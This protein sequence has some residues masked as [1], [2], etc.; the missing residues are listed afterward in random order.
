MGRIKTKPTKRITRKLMA[1]H[2][3]EFTD[4]FGKN[5]EVVSRLIVSSS[6]K[7]RNVI[8]GYITRLVKKNKQSEETV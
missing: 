3:K 1:L 6:N 5:K 4:D 8:S 7:I 2:G